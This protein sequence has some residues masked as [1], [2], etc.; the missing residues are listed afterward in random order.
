MNAKDQT[1][2]QNRPRGLITPQLSPQ[3]SKSRRIKSL[4][5]NIRNLLLGLYKV[6]HNITL[7]YMV[8]KEMIYNV[9]VLGPRVLHWVFGNVYGTSVI[10]EK[11]NIIQK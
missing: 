5:K 2:P 10:T 3:R 1:P 11:R 4:S 6:K 8:S 7:L 9:N